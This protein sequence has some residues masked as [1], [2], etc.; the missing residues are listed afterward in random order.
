M[1]ARTARNPIQSIRLVNGFLVNNMRIISH[2]I[3][4]LQIHAQSITELRARPLG[5]N[6]SDDDTHT[7]RQSSAMANHVT[8]TARPPIANIT[9]RES[10]H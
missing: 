7:Q 9:S 5:L 6:D 4:D 10:R 2:Y 1:K 8:G 3:Y